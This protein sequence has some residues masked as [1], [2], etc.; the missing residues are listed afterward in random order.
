M[1]PVISYQEM[2]DTLSSR[3][4]FLSGKEPNKAVML[5]GILLA[6]PDVP[7][8]KEQI[9]N[10]LE[11]FHVRSGDHIDFFCV[12]YGPDDPNDGYRDAQVEVL[13]RGWYFNTIHFEGVCREIESKTSWEYDGR[14]E[15]ILTNA[16]YDRE[17]CVAQFDFNSMIVCK[18]EKWMRIGAIEDVQDFFERIFRYAKNATGDDP[19]WGFSDKEGVRSLSDALKELVLSLVP[20][21][22]GKELSKTAVFAV[23]RG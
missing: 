2:M 17:A 14:T 20:K 4:S 21:N 1:H 19:T 13:D 8:A 9:I 15:L 23:Q 5:V 11:Y 18:L 10:S 22:F 12:G 7:L 16:R 3:L 6:R